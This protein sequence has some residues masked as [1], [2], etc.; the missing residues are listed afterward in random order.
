MRPGPQPVGAPAPLEKRLP[1]AADF[2]ITASILRANDIE[3]VGSSAID[4]TDA[5]QQIPPRRVGGGDLRA[6]GDAAIA[7]RGRPEKG[8]FFRARHETSE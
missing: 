8:S 1:L 7:G 2:E 4:V 3:D 6:L 5:G